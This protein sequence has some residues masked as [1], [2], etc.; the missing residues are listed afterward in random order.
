MAQLK[1]ILA[2][3]TLDQ[4]QYRGAADRQCGQYLCRRQ[5]RLPR[6]C[7]S[8]R[9]F[10]TMVLHPP[11][12]SAALLMLFLVKLS[13]D[14]KRDHRGKPN[15]GGNQTNCSGGSACIGRYAGTG[16][17]SLAKD[18]SGKHCGCWSNKRQRSACHAGRVCQRL[19]PAPIPALRKPRRR[20]SSSSFLRTWP[21]WS[22]RRSCPSRSVLFPFS[23]CPD[24][25]AR[26][27]PQ[28]QCRGLRDQ[29]RS[30]FR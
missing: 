24:Q 13:P 15:F 12:S 16:I 6:P 28:R 10:R 1:R 14:S 23:F 21:S 3:T 29:P 7:D 27:R 5:R 19:W 25:S 22:G 11:Q 4:N 18:S 26:N 17:S 9:H 20:A 2:A 8:R 30:G